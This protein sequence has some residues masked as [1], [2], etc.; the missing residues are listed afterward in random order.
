MFFFYFRQKD[1]VFC[2]FFDKRINLSEKYFPAILV[3]IY[4]YIYK[5]NTPTW[6]TYSFIEGGVMNVY[7]WCNNRQINRISVIFRF[8]TKGS[9]YKRN[10]LSCYLCINIYVYVQTKNLPGAYSFIEGGM[11]EIYK[12]TQAI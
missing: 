7:N 1:P 4:T 12:C 9:T 8:S 5:Q 6:C 2:F 11:M 3:K 10:V